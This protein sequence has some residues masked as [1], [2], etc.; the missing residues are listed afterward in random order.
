MQ[1]RARQNRFGYKRC[2]P[3]M[4]WRGNETDK[5]GGVRLNRSEC[6]GTNDS[7]RAVPAGRFPSID[8]PGGKMPPGFLLEFCSKKPSS[9][10]D[11]FKEIK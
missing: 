9:P 7:C 1:S 6:T 11:R 5:G 3:P 2:L 4:L 10:K 8:Y